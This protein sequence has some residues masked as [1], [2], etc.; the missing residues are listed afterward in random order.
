[1]QHPNSYIIL[2]RL[3]C[4]QAQISYLFP[5]LS[6]E[7]LLLNTC[8]RPSPLRSLAGD[9]GAK[10]GEVLVKYTLISDDDLRCK[11]GH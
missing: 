10:G 2:L 5:F 1:M 9:G 4:F 8:L 11:P 6:V 7:I 3:S